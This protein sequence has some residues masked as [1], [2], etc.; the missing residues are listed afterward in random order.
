ML[1][2]FFIIEIGDLE[3]E[4]FYIPGLLIYGWF[5]YFLDEFSLEE[6]NSVFIPKL[7]LSTFLNDSTCWEDITPLFECWPDYADLNGFVYWGFSRPTVATT[8]SPTPDWL[9]SCYPPPILSPYGNL[10]D[11][12]TPTPIFL[13]LIVLRFYLPDHTPFFH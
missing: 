1:I 4:D 6:L 5:L 9:E 10:V 11:L 12:D 7:I 13:S 3:L 8:E 2:L